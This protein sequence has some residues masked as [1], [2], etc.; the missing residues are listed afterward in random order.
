MHSESYGK[1]RQERETKQII[2]DLKYVPE[3]FSANEIVPGHC[4]LILQRSDSKFNDVRRRE[5]NSRI[6]RWED[7][8]GVPLRKFQNSSG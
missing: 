1:D 8:A 7:G 6:D 5:K 4:E 2:Q 3:A